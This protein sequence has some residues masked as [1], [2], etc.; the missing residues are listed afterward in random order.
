MNERDSLKTRP[1]RKA[2]PAL[3]QFSSSLF[4]DLARKTRF[5]D[6]NLAAAWPRIVG[7]D[8]AGL[9]RPGRITGAKSGRTLEV[10]VPNGAAAARIEFESARIREKVNGFLGPGVIARIAIRQAGGKAPIAR[11]DAGHLD[12]ALS[13]FRASFAARR[14]DGPNR[15]GDR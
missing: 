3:A 9:C 13:R 12:S 8:F 6:P 1:A 15:D 7:E 5:V 4:R 2:A 14:S 10:V 11:E